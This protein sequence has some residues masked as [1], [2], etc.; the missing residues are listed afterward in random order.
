MSAAWS[1]ELF[2]EKDNDAWLKMLVEKKE[3]SSEQFTWLHDLFEKKVHDTDGQAD[4]WWKDIFAGKSSFDH[5]SVPD[6]VKEHAQNDHKF[7]P[8]V[9]RSQRKFTAAESEPIKTPLI[10]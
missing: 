4:R 3:I 2:E 5:A 10:I 7:V 9:R 6:W 1:K 8:S